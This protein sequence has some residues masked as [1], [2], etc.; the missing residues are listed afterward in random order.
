MGGRVV[1][2]VGIRALLTGSLVITGLVAPSSG[3]LMASPAPSYHAS[4]DSPLGE[5][6]SLTPA[7]V[8]DTRDGTGRNG[9]TAPVG[10]GQTIDVQI[11]GQGGVAPQGVAA[12]WALVRALVLGRPARSAGQ[13][14]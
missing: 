11:T 2:S 13:R 12:V 14:P 9:I 8:L 3:A 5:F 1:R 6:T 10:E 7:R 4:A